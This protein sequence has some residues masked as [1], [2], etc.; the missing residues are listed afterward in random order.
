MLATKAALGLRV[1]ALAD[2]S[3]EGEGKGEHVTEE[4]KSALGVEGRLKIER[5]LAGLEGRPLKPKGIAIGPNGA[6][7]STPGKWEVK[8]ARKYNVDADGLVGDEPAAAAPVAEKAGKEKSKEV[9]MI[10][11]VKE[12]GNDEN[13][14]SEEDD[15]E[16]EEEN[17]DAEME[18]D[19]SSHPNPPL[20]SRTSS[21]RDFNRERYNLQ[22]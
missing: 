7:G 14:G 10:E 15:S 6:V 1:D 12:N 21:C 11:E 9:K 16:D 8:E 18:D 19:A 2:W 5:R 4:E 13:E 3:A 20:R 17:Q 22:W